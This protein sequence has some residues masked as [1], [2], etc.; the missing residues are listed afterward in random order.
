MADV[1]ALLAPI[2]QLHERIS[3]AVVE[4]CEAAAVDE[5]ARIVKEEEGDTIFA[6]DRV[7]EE[8]LVEVFEREVAPTTP[9][10]LIAEGLEGGQ[11][12]L[13]YGTP[14]SEAVWRI[15][16]DPID[17]TRGLMYQKRS[18]WV[19]TGVAPN[20]G[21]DTDLQD[22]ELAIQTEI[23]LVKQHLS[24][25]AWAIRGEGV[26]AERFNRLSG[27]RSALRLQP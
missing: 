17:G 1:H 26:H 15:I 5:L 16:V 13:P 25:V 14:E 22:I 19:L 11:I 10:V 23:P 3:A 2:R 9:L 27:E 21:P 12:T 6:V 8:L 18:A 7:S 24:D 20:L 4:A